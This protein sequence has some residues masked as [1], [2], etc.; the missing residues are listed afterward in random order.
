MCI[1]YSFDYGPEF[2]I[3]VC[4]VLRIALPDRFGVARGYV[5]SADGSFAGDDIIIYEKARF[6]TL[7]LR[8]KDSYLKKE[9]IPAE[10]VYCYIEAKHTLHIE[11]PDTDAKCGR[12]TSH[13]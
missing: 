7:G 12:L 11:S 5:V 9:Y 6:P 4:E 1:G 10:A 8:G 13:G 3:A 2:E